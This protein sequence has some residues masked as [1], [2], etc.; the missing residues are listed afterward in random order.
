MSTPILHARVR[1]PVRI[2]FRLLAGFVGIAGAVAVVGTPFLIWWGARVLTVGDIVMLPLM[3]WF[4]R[5]M[6][7][8][9]LHGKSPG[10]GECW[11]LASRGVWNCYLLL[12]LAYWM[13]TP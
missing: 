10:D 12:L 13:L 3:A 11:P 5:L 2:P 8:A 4:I 9:A 6:F 7:H 1:R